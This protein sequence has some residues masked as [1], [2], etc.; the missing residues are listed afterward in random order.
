VRTESEKLLD[1]FSL[2]DGFVKSFWQLFREVLSVASDAI[3]I[4]PNK[5]IKIETE[6][7][8]EEINRFRSSFSESYSLPP[9]STCRDRLRQ[10]KDRALNVYQKYKDLRK[11][12]EKEPR[13][14]ENLYTDRQYSYQLEK[15]EKLLTSIRQAE[16]FIARFSSYDKQKVLVLG[17][18]G[19]GKSHLLATTVATALRRKQPA[20]LVLGEQFLSDEVP[21]LQLCHI[22][23]W[24]DGTES[25]LGALNAAASVNGKPA[26]IAI[27]ALNESGEK[28]LWKSHLLQTAEQITKYPN[29]RILVS[30]RSDF[31]PFVLPASLTA[32]TAGEWFS[33]EH[34]GF[35]ENV[36]QAIATYFKGYSVTCDH[37]P[38]ILEE[39]K[40]PLFLKT[41]CETYA[42]DHVPSGT[43]SFDQILIK[44]VKKCQEKILAAIDCPEYTIKIAIDL[45]ASK[46]AENQGR[47]IPH[48]EIRPEID[49]L[50]D[51]G[52][53]SRSLYIHLRSNGMIV[54]SVRFKTVKQ[55][56]PETV[57]RFPYERFLDYFVASKL[58]DNFASIDD[59]KADWRKSG[60]PD[61]W[62]KDY[63]AL[64]GNRGLLRMLAILV[65]ERFGSEFIDLFAA[66]AVP[67]ELCQDFLISLAA[68]AGFESLIEQPNVPSRHDE[69]LTL[70]CH[71]S[72]RETL[73]VTQDETKEGQLKM[74]TD[75]R[76][77]LIPK[78]DKKRFLGMIEG[79]QFWGHGVDY[80]HFGKQWLGEYP[81]APSQKE[82]IDSTSTLDCW[83]DN[84]SLDINM[85]QTVCGYRNERS[86]ISARLP[87]PIICKLLDLRWAGEDFEYVNPDGELLAFC[88][89]SAGDKPDFGSP[90]LVRKGPFLSAIDQAGLI[91]I[92][93]ALSE[94]SC[95]SFKKHESI[96]KR[97]QITQRLYEFEKDHLRC[98]S[99][100]TYEI[101]HG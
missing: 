56:E 44:R 61:K 29:L 11:A 26:I 1:A 74:W 75:L 31:A 80:P 21:L 50:F 87:S 34:Q 83:I 89:A 85:C 6:E 76:C 53:E 86:R 10:C 94:R 96:V 39:F 43:L 23:G 17:E 99:D 93:A 28:R 41:F 60:L 14:K 19:T 91:A 36:F 32:G 22:F 12:E 13:G 66:L 82:I 4:A 25:L 62:I 27:D 88:P 92:W 95:Y 40:N 55:D 18:A 51:G 33:I 47:P 77:W 64:Y 45:L 65:P 8:S 67:V 90:L 42:N 78:E 81:W 20:I 3:E 15:L 35:G 98:C 59:L 52:G 72:W 100:R 7:L 101:P 58:L 37:F 73:S 69:W 68:P 38:P 54:E 49:R 24:E 9:I 5:S 71:Y 46:I 57:V 97:W 48:D 30:C 70:S 84:L 63:N 2:T 16:E 79:L